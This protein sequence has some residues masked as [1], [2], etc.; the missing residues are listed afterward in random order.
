MSGLG[1]VFF[2]FLLFFAGFLVGR[3][4]NTTW[5]SKYR[6]IF[7]LTIF[8]LFSLGVRIGSDKELISRLDEISLYAFLIATTTVVGSAVFAGLYGRKIKKRDLED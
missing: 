5:I 8:L 6:L 7:V 4:F 1:I 3:F 2:V